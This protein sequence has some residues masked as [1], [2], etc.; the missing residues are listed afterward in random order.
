MSGTRKLVYWDS[1]IF[2]AWLSQ[3]GRPEN[4][5][6]TKYYQQLHAAGEITI[7]TSTI[8]RVEVLE[9]KLQP[10]RAEMFKAFLNRGGDVALVNV[11]AKIAD[12]AHDLRDYYANLEDGLG[13]LSVPDALHLA[14]AI[15]YKCDLFLTLDGQDGDRK[16][17]DRRLIPL[18][19]PIAGRH[20]LKIEAPVR[21]IKDGEF[22]FVYTPR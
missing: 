2:L 7:V 17:K 22:T 9:S 16:G 8:T 18:A 4:L 13:K 6:G 14:T 5:D 21:P 12:L 11:G 3:K 10:D 19:M 20:H 15:N 1:A